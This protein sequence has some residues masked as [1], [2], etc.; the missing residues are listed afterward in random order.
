VGARTDAA[1]AEVLAAREQLDGE[2]VR[3]EASA[4]AAVD[5]PAKVRRDPVKTAGLAAGAGFVL[6]GGP[7]RLFRRARRAVVGP[8]DPMPRQMLPKEVDK[9]LRKLGSDGEKVRRVLEREFATYL[10]E[11]A[12]KRKERDL[13]AVVALA[14]AG[15]A[16]PVAQRVGRQLVQQLFSP[17]GP[18]FAEQ[19]DRI[20]D[21]AAGGSSS[22]GASS[23]SG[24]KQDGAGL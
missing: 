18:G 9:E 11:T 20:R 16:R 24:T 4:R 21:R 14:L 17:D 22:G 3:L 1:R 6:L 7:Q 8:S 10:E 19:M 12:E 23:G 15:V 13:S 5:I 2:L